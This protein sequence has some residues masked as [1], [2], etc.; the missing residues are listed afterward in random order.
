MKA[1][2]AIKYEV[3]ERKHSHCYGEASKSNEVSYFAVVVAWNRFA[4]AYSGFNINKSTNLQNCI[5]C[6]CGKMEIEIL[7]YFIF[8]G[9]CGRRAWNPTI[10]IE[11]NVSNPPPQ[12]CGG[13]ARDNKCKKQKISITDIIW[14]KKQKK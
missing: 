5:L 11:N 9:W 6:R 8:C 2:I 12:C 4:N 3:L 13:Q 14:Y 7:K 10:N 1:R